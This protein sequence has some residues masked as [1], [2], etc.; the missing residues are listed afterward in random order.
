MFT[1]VCLF[2]V[3]A[4]GQMNRWIQSIPSHPVPLRSILILSS[5]P[6]IDTVKPVLNGPFIKRNFVLSGNIF[7][8]RDYH[9]KPWLNGNLAS[10][11]KMFWTLEIPFKTGFTVFIWIRYWIL[12]SF[13]ITST[14][15]KPYGNVS[16][17]YGSLGICWSLSIVLIILYHQGTEW[18][19]ISQL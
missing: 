16:V 5:H 11:K 4:L 10:A 1:R 18:E 12:S 13:S 6:Y 15:I 2:V 9:S 7:R 14:F 3:A 19:N 17:I 8:S